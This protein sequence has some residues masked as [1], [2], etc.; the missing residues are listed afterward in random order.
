MHSVERVGPVKSLA[1]LDPPGIERRYRPPDDLGRSSPGIGRGSDRRACTDRRGPFR[2]SPRRRYRLVAVQR[3]HR[4]RVRSVNVRVGSGTWGTAADGEF[5]LFEHEL[6]V[7]VHI[8]AV[9]TV[10]R[11]VGCRTA[12][13]RPTTVRSSSRQRLIP[14]ARYRTAAVTHPSIRI[15]SARRDPPTHRSFSRR[16]HKEYTSANERRC[17]GRSVDAQSHDGGS[18]FHSVTIYVG[19]A[20][21]LRRLGR[22]RTRVGSPLVHGRPKRSD[23]WLSPRAARHRGHVGDKTDTSI[24]GSQIVII[25]I[26]MLSAF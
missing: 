11:H 21:L 6:V 12:S 13:T 8:S 10:A 24:P 15:G 22:S 1:V 3:T 18:V 7:S 2:V 16:T 5:C 26:P 9:G 20:A 14:D 23:G 17:A 25:T 19:E 4:R